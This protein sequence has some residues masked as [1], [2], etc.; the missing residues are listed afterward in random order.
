MLV[1]YGRG[2]V[3]LGHCRDREALA[4]F[5]AA[6]RMARRLA[7]LRGITPRIRAL[8]LLTLV[9]LGETERAG[10]ALAD[11]GEQGRNGGEIR[12][13]TAA[14]RL[15]QDDPHAA[16]AALAPVLDGSA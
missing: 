11:L 10:Q 3:E 7:A 8:L 9:R 4:A 5:E 2:L 16:V 14:L 13:A 1:L 15:A 12:I 6:D